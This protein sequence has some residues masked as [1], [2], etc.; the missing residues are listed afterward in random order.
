MFFAVTLRQEDAQTVVE[1]ILEAYGRGAVANPNLLE[2][3]GERLIRTQKHR[4]QELAMSALLGAPAA[5]EQSNTPTTSGAPAK[6]C[7]RRAPRCACP[8]RA[9]MSSLAVNRVQTTYSTPF[10]A[11]SNA[12]DVSELDRRLWSQG[13]G[14]VDRE[15]N[16]KTGGPDKV[17]RQKGSHR[18]ET[19]NPAPR[20]SGGFDASVYRRKAFSS[21]HVGELAFDD[22]RKG[23]RPRARVKGEGGGRAAVT[24]LLPVRNGGSFLLDAVMSVFICAAERHAPVPVELLIIDDGSDDGS[25]DHVVHACA[26]ANIL[27]PSS[28]GLKG[29]GDGSPEASPRRGAVVVAVPRALRALS[30]AANAVGGDPD[31]QRCWVR[32]IRHRRSMGLAQCLNEGLREAKADLVARMDADDVCVPRRLKQ[33]VTLGGGLVRVF[34]VM[35]Q[36]IL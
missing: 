23:G 15:S 6:K 1:G 36:A 8:G 13:N 9:V 33:Q 26:A 11:S 12:G 4:S 31:K 20:G 19:A 28:R 21:V 25:I 32:I 3:N 7:A 29:L 27:D 30:S 16:K 2:F 18:D 24:V 14:D 5:A 17:E 22:E 10:Y 35:R 34:E